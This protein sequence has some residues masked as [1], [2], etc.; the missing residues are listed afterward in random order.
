M[1]KRTS[2]NSPFSTPGT[3]IIRTV[4]QKTLFLNFPQPQTSPKKVPN[5]V[6]GLLKFTRVAGFLQF[7]SLTL[8][9]DHLANVTNE[10]KL[11]EVD[12]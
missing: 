4:F 10:N 2:N 9:F 5:R 11:Q 7:S 12:E 8:C 3:L 6:V 1:G